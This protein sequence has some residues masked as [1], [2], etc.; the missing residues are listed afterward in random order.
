SVSDINDVI[1]GDSVIARNNDNHVSTYNNNTGIATVNEKKQT[2]RYTN[3]SEDENNI[4]NLSKSIS[5]SFKFINEHAGFTDEFRLFDTD[6]KKS[7]VNYK[8]FL[9]NYPVFDEDNRS[10]ERRVWKD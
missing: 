10:E 2:Y 4:N 5:N 1:L 7:N 6:P 3:L 9:N 8:M